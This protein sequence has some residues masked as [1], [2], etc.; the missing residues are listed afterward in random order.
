MN[1]PT[2]PTSPTKHQA[3]AVALLSSAKQGCPQVILL[4]SVNTSNVLGDIFRPNTLGPS[5]IGT[6]TL[7]KT[8]FFH[9][10]L[11]FSNHL[12]GPKTRNMDR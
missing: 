7:S 1:I 10:Y 5:P 3:Q 12:L 11:K 2:G 9:L 8:F 6:M 4:V